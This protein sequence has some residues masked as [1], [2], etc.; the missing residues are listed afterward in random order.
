M[1]RDYGERGLMKQ[2][3]DVDKDDGPTRRRVRDG[4]AWR[5][6]ERDAQCLMPRSRT[7][8]IPIYILFD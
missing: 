1:T 2:D 6:A 4:M 3:D 5:R 8:R 7:K